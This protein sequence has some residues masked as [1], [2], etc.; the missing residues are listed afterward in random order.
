MCERDD[1]DWHL[2]AQEGPFTWAQVQEGYPGSTFTRLVPDPFAEPVALPWERKSGS[3]Y[4]FIATDGGDGYLGLTVGP[5]ENT[6][7]GYSVTA[8]GARDMARALWAAADAAEKEQ[9]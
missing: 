2:A 9:S 4:V 8:D 5:T 1:D 7:D 6:A 3:P